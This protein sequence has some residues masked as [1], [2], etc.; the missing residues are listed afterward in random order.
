VRFRVPPGLHVG[1]F[2]V[3][4]RGRLSLLKQYPPQAAVTW[5]EYPTS[6]KPL[7]LE[8][9]T[10]T[11][12]LLVCGRATGPLSEAEMRAAW[13]DGEAW[14]ELSPPQR[15]LRLSPTGVQEEWE[16]RRDWSEGPARP[17]LYVVPR[18]LDQLRERLQPTCPL[19]EGLAFAHQ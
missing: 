1:L 8:A 6:N 16:R 2:A 4:G 13:D 17:D 3:N 5:L 11:E 7:R 12:V 14:P 19:L 18:R 9:P 10:G 15:L